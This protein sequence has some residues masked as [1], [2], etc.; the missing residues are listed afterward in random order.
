MFAE[1]MILPK[2]Q[3]EPKKPKR[4]PKKKAATAKRSP[5]R[6]PSKSARSR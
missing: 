4:A 2:K 1:P 5:K 3:A 6:T